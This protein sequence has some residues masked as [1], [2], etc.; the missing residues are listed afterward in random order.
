MKQ[1][2][3]IPNVLS[4]AGSDPSGGAGIQA[5]LKTF[6]ALG[7]YGMAAIT[8]LTAQNTQGVTAI[9][10]VPPDFVAAQIDTIFADIDVA[11]VKLGLLA[12]PEILT[13]IAQR[14]T[15]HQARSIVLDPVLVA[16]SGDRLGSD[17]L[18][19]AMCI[20]LAPMA[21]VITPNLPEAAALSGLPLAN[22]LSEIRATAV[23]ILDQGF[24]HVLIK[25][26]HAQTQEATDYLFSRSQ[27]HVFSAPRINTRN[28]H[29]TGCTLSSA[30]AAFLAKGLSLP[31]AITSAKNYLTRA[32]QQA[33]ELNVGHGHGPLQHFWS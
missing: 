26:G 24:S 18:V 33:D 6:G 28:T 15:Y 17:G 12:T 23:R 11:S 4:I 21:A 1:S 14:L 32:L 10:P 20:H 27:E 22:S 7:C 9:Q 3:P 30:I 8:S 29:G 13:R 19:E 31:E 2:M 16:T 5:D 25:G